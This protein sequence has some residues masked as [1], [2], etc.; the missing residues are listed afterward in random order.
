[1]ERGATV[2][3]LW[4]TAVYTAVYHNIDHPFYFARLGSV[5]SSTLRPPSPR[6]MTQLRDMLMQLH[7][8]RTQHA[9]ATHAA[10]LPYMGPLT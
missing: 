8:M 5:L 3:P 2:T 1:M 6:P 9:C 7:D 10:V 4:S